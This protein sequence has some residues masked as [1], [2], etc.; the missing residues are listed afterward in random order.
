LKEAKAA[1]DPVTP[2]IFNPNVIGYWPLIDSIQDFSGKDDPKLLLS[3][4]HCED[5]S[6]FFDKQF[7]VSKN[8]TFNSE[9]APLI[10]PNEVIVW[11]GRK[12][13]YHNIKING[14]QSPVIY[15]LERDPD[16]VHEF[17]F[18]CDFKTFW[19]YNENDYCPGCIVQIYIGIRNIFSQGIIEYYQSLMHDEISF[20]FKAASL[21]RGT[22]LI[23]QTIDLMYNF[24]EDRT[25]YNDLKS[26][27]AIIH[28]LPRSWSE[29]NH[30][31]L[32]FS[33]RKDIENLQMV[34][35]AKNMAFDVFHQIANRIIH[36]YLDNSDAKV[37]N[38]AD[39]LERTQL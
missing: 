3:L 15:V 1:G 19:E 7:S 23:T 2:T 35:K 14:I 5:W 18:S 32:P 13:S 29:M 6:I 38:L 9:F 10:R 25:H 28:V 11:E 39:R 8:D 16:A 37:G 20:D 33:I 17:T 26:T 36:S 21:L 27:L 22:Y 30:R 4:A 34:C 12:I 31:F 24:R